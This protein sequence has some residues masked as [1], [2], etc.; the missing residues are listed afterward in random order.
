MY[1]FKLQAVLDHRQFCEDNLKKELADIRHHRLA[2]QQQLN[3]LKEKEMDTGAALKGEQKQGISS[4]Q[5]VTYHQFLQWLSQCMAE[6][7]TMVAQLNQQEAAKQVELGE[8]MKKRKI[9]EKLKDQGLERYNQLMLKKEVNFI[10]EIAVNQF[11]R[12]TI[13]TRGEGQ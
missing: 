4:G 9:L 8:A 12:N 13:H 3:A 6:Q 2:A 11:V 5:V 7:K 1:K 10:D